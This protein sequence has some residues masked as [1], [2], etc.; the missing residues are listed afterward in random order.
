MLSLRVISYNI[1]ADQYASGDFAQTTLFP[2]CPAYAIDMDYRKQLLLKEISGTQ[3][4]RVFKLYII[5]LPFIDR[6]LCNLKRITYINVV[7]SLLIH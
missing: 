5:I 4:N 7:Q 1:L 3:Q 6:V 2:T